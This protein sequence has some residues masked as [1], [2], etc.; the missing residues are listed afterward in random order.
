[1]SK[2]LLVIL[3]CLLATFAGRNASAQ[4]N[5]A[6]GAVTVAPSDKNLLYMGR[7]DR[8]DPANSHGFWIGSYVRVNFTGTSVG[9]NLGGN[10]G[11]ECDH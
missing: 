1:M 6:P 8:S 9:I 5:A 3:V 7:W 10:S 2:F 11:L 4:T